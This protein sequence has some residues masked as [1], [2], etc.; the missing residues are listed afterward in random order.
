MEEKKKAA[1]SRLPKKHHLRIEQEKREAEEKA[2]LAELER[3]P[4]WFESIKNKFSGKSRDSS[5]SPAKK[6]P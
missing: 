4:T 5:K 6:T 2:R 1:K 3:K